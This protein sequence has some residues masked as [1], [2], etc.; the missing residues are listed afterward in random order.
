L[1]YA[2]YRYLT[3]IFNDIVKEVVTHIGGLNQFCD[4]RMTDTLLVEPQTDTSSL[5]KG[6]YDRYKEKT[7]VATPNSVTPQIND[8]S[9]AIL[10]E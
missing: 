7:M 4:Y 9:P 8:C 1:L 6:R 5:N 10:A 2:L 3:Q